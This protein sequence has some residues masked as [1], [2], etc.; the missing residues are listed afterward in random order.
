MNAP[1]TK[2]S[3]GAR[4][5]VTNGDSRH[6]APG[7]KLIPE[8]GALMH[9]VIGC[10]RVVPYPVVG[11]PGNML[12]E[13]GLTRLGADPVDTIM[14]G[15]NP[16]TDAV[17]AVRLGMPY[18]LVGT[19]PQADAPSPSILFKTNCPGHVRAPVSISLVDDYRL[20]DR[21]NTA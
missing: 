1:N 2:I 13:E 18:L 17:G 7:G 20:A 16:S 5:V 10:L 9:A 19:T 4:S 12:F 3:E 21:L 15:D 14:I 6:P 11:K 8:T